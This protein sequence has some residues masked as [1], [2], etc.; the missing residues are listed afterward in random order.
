M[1]SVCHLSRLP[2]CSVS[3]KAADGVNTW[4]DYLNDQSMHVV[5]AKLALLHK[6]PQPI[7][8]QTGQLSNKCLI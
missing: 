8:Q 5:L 1:S 4:T 7:G 2:T 3:C 6:N